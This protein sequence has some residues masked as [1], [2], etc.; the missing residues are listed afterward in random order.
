AGGETAEGYP[1]VFK[2]IDGGATWSP[3]GTGITSEIAQVLVVDPTSPST[4]Y[5]ATYDGGVFKSTDGGGLSASLT[6]SPQGIDIQALIMDPTSSST[7]YLATEGQGPYKTTDG[8]ATWT[9]KI[10]GLLDPNAPFIESFRN[11]AD[12]SIAVDPQNPSTLYLG[13]LD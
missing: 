4:I 6:T 10:T 1:P 2:S 9:Q 3:S 7:L 11:F 5:A 12:E 8:G 13:T